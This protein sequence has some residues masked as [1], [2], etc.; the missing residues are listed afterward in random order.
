[1]NVSIRF[2]RGLAVL[3]VV[4]TPIQITPVPSCTRAAFGMQEPL[5]T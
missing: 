3:P 1:M 5:R 2:S 4:N